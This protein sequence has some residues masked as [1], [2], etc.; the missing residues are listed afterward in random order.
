M[1]A[2]RD[3]KADVIRHAQ[4]TGAAD[5]PTHAIE[6]L[7]AHLEDIYLEA[8]RSGRSESDAQRAASAKLRESPLR[9]VAAE[10]TRGPESRP[11]NEPSAGRGLTGLAGDVRWAWRQ[12]R[13]APSFAAIAI[14]TLGLGAGAATAIFSIVDTV[15]LR[16]LPFH[17]PQQLVS[18]WESNAEKALPKEKL[19]PVNFMDYRNTQT[20]FSE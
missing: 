9:G 17:E 12:W 18:I 8:I 13:R 16:P 7:A 10:R 3:W 20:A 2:K 15:L 6:E 11:I 5:L 1:T 19:S 14:L 4:A